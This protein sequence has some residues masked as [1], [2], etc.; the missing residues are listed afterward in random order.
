[1]SRA[2]AIIGKSIWWA[3]DC[4]PRDAP[5]GSYVFIGRAVCMLGEA[6]YPGEWKDDDPKL[7]FTSQRDPEAS[8]ALAVFNRLGAA[9]AAKHLPFVL[10]RQD[11]GAFLLPRERDPTASFS[12]DDWNVDDFKP[13]FGLGQMRFGVWQTEQVWI[14]LEK[15]GLDE[16]MRLVHGGSAAEQLANDFHL[17]P[18]LRIMIEVARKL[19]ISPSNQPNKESL[20]AEIRALWG[21]L[22]SSE[23]LASAMATLLREPASQLGKAK[24]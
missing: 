16:L 12:A 22:P 4:W 3:K 9:V 17:S 21:E 8:R 24:K 14:Y 15:K 19:Q 1:M 18:Y 23:R 7:A 6:M 11:G 13:L 10:R 2:T 5:D 20:E